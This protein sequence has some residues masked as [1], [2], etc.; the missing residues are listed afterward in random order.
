MPYTSPSAE[1]YK[2]VSLTSSH[3]QQWL[4]DNS[5][6]VCHLLIDPMLRPLED[7]EQLG[8]MLARMQTIPCPV[9]L[10][11]KS[12]MP[13]HCPC[14][15]TI[16]TSQGNGSMAVTESVINGLVELA[17]QD[18]QSG[19]GRRIG[20][21]LVSPEPASS[22]AAHLARVMVQSKGD[23]QRM[24]LRLNDPAVI[25]PLYALLSPSQRVAAFGPIQHWWLLDPAG[26]PVRLE[27]PA[28]SE[29]DPHATRL[30]LTPGQWADVMRLDAFNRAINQWI[31]EALQPPAAPLVAH[32][33]GVALLALRRAAS[34]GLSDTEDLA[35]FAMHALTVSPEF[36]R[37]PVVQALLGRCRKEGNPTGDYFCAAVD[38]LNDTDWARIRT[39]TQAHG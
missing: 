6:G 1:L 7:D 16:D 10:P 15:S 12:V 17:P 35:R 2:R 11:E 39:E 28:I 38:D 25:W 21:W 34:Y 26:H 29:D 4:A 36:D 5:K 19:K 22:L 27:R 37:H 32:M 14:L 30:D 3:L 18:L 24:L 8:Q 33:A 9:R 20:G 31:A 23:G 13:Q